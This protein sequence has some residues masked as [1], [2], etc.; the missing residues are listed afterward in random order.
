MKNEQFQD[1]MKLVNESSRYLINGKDAKAIEHLERAITSVDS[2]KSEAYL[3]LLDIYI[4][5]DETDSGLAKIEI[6]INDQYGHV[7]KNNEVL[8]KMGMTYF[9]IKS[10]YVSALKYF[11]K[12]DEEEI[13][14]AKYYKSLAT[15]MGSLNVDYNKFTTNLREFEKY[16]DSLANDHKKLITIILW[17]IY[18]FHIKGKFLMPIPKP[19]WSF[20]RQM[21]S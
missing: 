5:R 14:D 10:D 21:A 12:V 19:S 15:T 13:P 17:Q 20:K 3:N 1:Y 18:I 4:N 7:D 8:F 16:N 2:G 9:D 6:Y 11:Q